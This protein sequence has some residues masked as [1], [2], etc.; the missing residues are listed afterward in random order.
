MPRSKNIAHVNWSALNVDCRF[1]FQTTKIESSNLK[2][3]ES[4][5]VTSTI[6]L[7]LGGKV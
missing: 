1:Q 4:R 6:S 5:H 2:S 7:N 3:A